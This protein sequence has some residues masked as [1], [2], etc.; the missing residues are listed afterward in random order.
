MMIDGH[1]VQYY[2]YHGA[3]L[4]IDG[5][6]IGYYGGEVTSQ[7]AGSGNSP[8]P[9]SFTGD[10]GYYIFPNGLIMQW[11]FIF[12]ANSRTT[13]I[14]YSIPFPH[15]TLQVLVTPT[16][17][18]SGGSK[19]EQWFYEAHNWSQYGFDVFVWDNVGMN[20]IFS[21]WILKTRCVDN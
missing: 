16:G 8:D 1:H 13:S 15:K 2:D 5:K 6:N 11:G 10:N 19:G 4:I 3:H 17:P 7:G 14:T 12:I 21:N 18:K 20:D 9:G